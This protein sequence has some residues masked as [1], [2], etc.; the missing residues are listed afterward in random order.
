MSLQSL[1]YLTLSLVLPPLLYTFTDS[2]AIAYT[3][4]GSATVGMVMD[5]RDMAGRSSLEHSPSL[6]EQTSEHLKSWWTSGDALEASMPLL[7]HGDMDAHVDPSITNKPSWANDGAL[8]G[9]WRVSLEHAPEGRVERRGLDSPTP[10]LAAMDAPSLS[11]RDDTT[12]ALSPLA[13]AA[14]R[15]PLRGWIISIGW[16]IASA[17]E[18][19]PFLPVFPILHPQKPTHLFLYL[20]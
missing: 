2:R 3:H 7:G 17:A 5:W 20:T 9:G 12:P 14:I 13:E 6:A 19:V 15:D 1:H 11:R 10:S 4:G 18:C 8:L 16:V